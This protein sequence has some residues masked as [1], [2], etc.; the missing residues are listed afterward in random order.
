MISIKRPIAVYYS[1][2]KNLD[3]K[4]DSETLVPSQQTRGLVTEKTK[5]R[6]VAVV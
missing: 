2:Y 4:C 3:S 1:S 6:I 5:I